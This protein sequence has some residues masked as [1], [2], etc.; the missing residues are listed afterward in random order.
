MANPLAINPG[1]VSGIGAMRTLARS[2]GIGE[3]E[4]SVM[5][6]R[7]SFEVQSRAKGVD[8]ADRALRLLYPQD[9]TPRSS[10]NPQM[11]LVN[12]IQRALTEIQHSSL[13]HRIL[14]V[15]TDGTDREIPSQTLP[16]FGNAE[17]PIYVIGFVGNIVRLTPYRTGSPLA[18]EIA[19]QAPAAAT[20]NWLSRIAESTGG[21]AELFISDQE[22]VVDRLIAFAKEVGADVRGQYRLGYYSTVPAPAVVRVRAGSFHVR[23]HR[24]ASTIAVPRQD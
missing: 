20:E 16:N 18:Q 15:A 24:L 7:T 3:D 10:T 5:T 14:I 11:T 17:I 23:F 22:Q 21:R 6:F 8:A 9:L 12:A 13:E 4:F 19:A 1:L 2:S